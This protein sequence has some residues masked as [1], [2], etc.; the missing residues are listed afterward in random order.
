MRTTFTL[1][2]DARGGKGGVGQHGKGAQ[3]NSPSECNPT[4]L[5]EE[6][7]NIDGM[8]MDGDLE[9]WLLGVEIVSMVATKMERGCHL[10]LVDANRAW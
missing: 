7:K 3:S 10:S 9:A 2:D 6:R 1:R 5:R 8:R 4:Y